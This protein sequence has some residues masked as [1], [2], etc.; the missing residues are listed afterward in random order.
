MVRTM[1]QPYANGKASS[2]K[3]RQKTRLFM[4]VIASKWYTS[5]LAKVYPPRSHYCQTLL[6]ASTV[7]SLTS[8]SSS[9]SFMLLTPGIVLS[10][11]ELEENL[12]NLP[13]LVAQVEEHSWTKFV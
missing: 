10:D 3:E 5:R 7:V 9:V 4:S 2:L 13:L 1:I 8:P 12:E 11:A 6:I